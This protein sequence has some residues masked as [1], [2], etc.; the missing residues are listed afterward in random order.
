MHVYSHKGQFLDSNKLIDY[1]KF[2]NLVLLFLILV[3]SIGVI[4]IIFIFPFKNYFDGL[5]SPWDV[6]KC[7]TYKARYR[8]ILVTLKMYKEPTYS[9][10]W[11]S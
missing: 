1:L 2:E 3:V 9:E 7:F 6:S 8:L 10:A 4:V 5:T 11:N